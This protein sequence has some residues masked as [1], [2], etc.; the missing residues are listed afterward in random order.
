MRGRTR[1]SDAER[2]LAG[3]PGK[4]KPKARQVFF[5]VPQGCPPPPGE[6]SEEA[7]RIWADQI[8]DVVKMVMLQ[9]QGYQVFAMYCDAL[10]RFWKYTQKLS[11]GE[12]YKTDTGFY[13]KKPEVELRDRAFS[14]VVK[15]ASEL[16]LTPKSWI[17]STSTREG[18]ALD[19][20]ARQLSLFGESGQPVAPPSSPGAAQET[21][22][23]TTQETDTFDSYLKDRSVH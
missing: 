4:R 9:R 3:N 14:D 13:R 20:V 17:A 1:K 16:N 2:E 15:L 6:L 21:T 18:R 7:Q 23:E 8:A 5:S 22:Q 10:S 19:T 11:R 12:T